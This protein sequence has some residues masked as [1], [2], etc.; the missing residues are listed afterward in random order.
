MWKSLE[1]ST[2]KT[3]VV[4]IRLRVRFPATFSRDLEL[5]Y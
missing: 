1:S 3:R 4:D 5:V 2:G